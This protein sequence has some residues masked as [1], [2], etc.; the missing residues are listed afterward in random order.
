MC[1]IKIYRV[2]Q[3]HINIVSPSRY[4][5]KE[6]HNHS[7][8]SV[9]LYLLYNM[10]NLAL[11]HFQLIHLITS[12]PSNYWLY[13]RTSSR[14]EVCSLLGTSRSKLY[15]ETTGDAASLYHGPW[16]WWTWT[17]LWFTVECILG[18]RRVW[19]DAVRFWAAFRFRKRGGISLSRI[20]SARCL[21]ILEW[22]LGT[23]FNGSSFPC[24]W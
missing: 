24:C 10:F 23:L 15:E 1:S 2:Q 12:L 5:Y 6:H 4:I 20:A 22:D 11:I 7:L 21:G 9:F 19:N 17:W 8:L 18:D 16:V 3:H 13:L 14:M